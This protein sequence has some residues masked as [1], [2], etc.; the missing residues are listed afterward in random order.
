MASARKVLH[1]AKLKASYGFTGNIV[2]SASPQ[3][4]MNYSLQTYREYMNQNHLVGTISSAPNPN[5]GWEKVNDVKVG[6]DP[7][8]SGRPA[9]A[10]NGVLQPSDQRRR[11][12]QAALR[13][14]GIHP[15]GG[16]FRPPAQPGYRVHAPGRDRSDTGLDAGCF[17]QFRFQLEQSARICEF[18]IVPAYEAQLLRGLSG[19]GAHRRARW[20]GSTP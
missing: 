17:G 8:I 11:G 12:R 4:M 16:Q 13:D 20:S 18:G 2:T 9:F 1:Y 14:Y 6:L 3:L 19:P 15:S 5:L 7:G 10:R